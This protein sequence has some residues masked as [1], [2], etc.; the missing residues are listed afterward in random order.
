V[1]LIESIGLMQGRLLPKYKTRYQAHPIGYWQGEFSIAKKLGFS[2]IEFIYD[3]NDH[4]QNPLYSAEGI[5]AIQKVVKDTGV[6]VRSV[7]ADYFMEAPLHHID[8]EIA[9]ASTVIL[10][11]LIHN[12]SKIGINDIVLPCVDQ[13]ALKN[14]DD[15]KRFVDQLLPL[16][17]I[18]EQS[19]INISLE[20]DLSPEEFA[21]LLYCFSS[22]RVTVNYDTGNSASLGY[23]LK[24]EFACYGNRISDIHIKDRILGGGSVL[25]GTG[26]TNFD[27]FFEAFA[28][29][30]Y[31]GPIIMQAYRDDE[32]VSITKQQLD[33]FLNKAKSFE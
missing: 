30:N 8:S 5:T 7:C 13:S 19:S 28:S 14:S 6:G 4:E 11:Q 12:C 23:N 10:E 24:D 3:Y 25:L 15:K 2:C 22:P 9:N 16:Q 26:N 21:E 32:G 27:T 29:M 17:E 20:T 18:L 31:H 33:W 1:A